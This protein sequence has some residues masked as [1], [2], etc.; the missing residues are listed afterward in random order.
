MRDR[1]SG[2]RRKKRLALTVDDRRGGFERR[3]PR[4]L[5]QF[6]RDRPYR[7]LAL[8]VA[9]NVMNVLDLL[10]TMGALR[11]GL[12]EGNPVMGLLLSAGYP[13][14]IVFKIA[15]VA[16]AS[17]VMWWLRRYRATAVGVI[18]A[19]SVYALLMVY[20]LSLAALL[21]QRLPAR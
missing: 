10:L 7:L 13:A 5:L 12:A 20:Q 4:M 16:A 2:E 19:T 18:V 1:R 21:A 3:N 8:L 15:L 14:G 9:L 11:S 17:L 6:F